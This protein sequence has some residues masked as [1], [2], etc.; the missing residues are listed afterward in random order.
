MTVDSKHKTKNDLN[1]NDSCARCKNI[2]FTPYS[3]LLWTCKETLFESFFISA[4]VEDKWNRVTRE[5]TR[6]TAEAVEIE[7]DRRRCSMLVINVLDWTHYN[8]ALSDFILTIAETMVEDLR[9]PQ[10]DRPDKPRGRL[11][12]FEEGALC[13]V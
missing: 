2:F 9:P 10:P 1:I 3:R 12:K 11:L 5:V 8:A 4:V 13:Q 6:G 7:G